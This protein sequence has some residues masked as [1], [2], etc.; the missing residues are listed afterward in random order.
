MAN[1]IG[2]ILSAAMLC[3]ESLNWPE[4]ADCIE[5]AVDQVLSAGVRTADLA[6]KGEKPI[7]TTEMGDRIAA[8]LT[9]CMAAPAQ[10]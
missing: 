6:R 7:G 1:P 10:T 8:A 3:R 9:A 5:A 2:M 4:A